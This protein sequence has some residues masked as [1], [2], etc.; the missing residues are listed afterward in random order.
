MKKIKKGDRICCIGHITH[1]RIITPR[2]E[3]NMPGGTAYYFAKALRHLEHDRFMLVTGVAEDALQVVA[4]L[5][6]EGIDVEVVPSRRTVFFE[7]AYGEDMNDRRQRVLAKADPFTIGSLMGIEAEVYHLGTLLADDFS[8]EVI[9][10]LSM[11]GVVSVDIQGYLREVEG[12]KVKPVDFDRKL[13]AL[14]YIDILKANEKEMETL[15]GATDPYEAARILAS[16]GAGEVLLTLGDRGSLIYS[17]GMFHEIPAY[18]VAEAVDATGC[19][20]TYMAGYLYKRS[21]GVS[22]DE[23]GRFAAA[24]CSLK[25]AQK[26]PFNGTEKDVSALIS[27][28]S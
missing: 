12:D 1:D 3:A 10:E 4:G 9:K 20:D 23:A 27:C 7:N 28:G 17:E 13:E 24:M 26:G 25:L 18:P 8:V 5:R 15:T 16:W 2:F 6:K 19:G 21:Q 11:R 14:P 22:I